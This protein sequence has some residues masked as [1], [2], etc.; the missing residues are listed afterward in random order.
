MNHWKITL[1][2]KRDSDIPSFF[3]GESDPKLPQPREILIV[4][5]SIDQRVVTFGDEDIPRRGTVR[6][7]GDVEDSRGDVQ[8]LVGLELVSIVL[9]VMVLL[10]IVFVVVFDIILGFI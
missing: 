6:Y 9:R 5:K 10:L 8:I 2:Q 3:K 1:S 4:L 7:I